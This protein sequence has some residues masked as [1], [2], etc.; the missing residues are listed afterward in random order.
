VILRTA[1]LTAS[2]YEWAHHVPMATAAGVRPEQIRAL[3]AWEE[4]AAFDEHERA[5]LRCT[6]EVHALEVSDASFGELVRVLGRPGA[7]EIVLTASFYQAVARI[8]QALGLEVEPAYQPYLAGP[9]DDP[10]EGG[11]PT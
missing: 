2:A 4:S 8:V 11:D 3:A 7:V 1:Q 10:E 6:E 9:A 5:T